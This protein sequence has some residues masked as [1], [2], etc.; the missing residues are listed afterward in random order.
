MLA[1]SDPT[2]SLSSATS[3]KNKVYAIRKGRNGISGVVV[4]SWAACKAHTDG[5]SGALYKSF[6]VESAGDALLWAQGKEIPASLD[7][8]AATAAPP[9]PAKKR[10]KPAGVG[11]SELAFST[12]DFD[13][14][15]EPLYVF[16]DGSSV[17]DPKI[18]AR[19]GGYGIWFGEK[20][21]RNVSEPFALLEP[22]NNRCEL[23]ALI[24][25]IEIVRE[26][27]VGGAID[28]RQ[29]LVICTDSRYAINCVTKWWDKWQ[30]NRWKNNT[31]KN[32]KLIEKLRSLFTSRPVALCYV[33]GHAG[34]EGNEGADRLARQAS[35]N[36]TPGAV[37][38][39]P[40]G[41]EGGEEDG[42]DEDF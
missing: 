14:G 31:V 40:A 16:A 11:D 38:G 17:L 32:R 2:V 25:T 8:A 10:R 28:P 7:A 35:E 9:A 3:G 36:A 37:G 22:T 18:N 41:G 23:M 12:K 30:S 4:G 34:I 26:Y 20:D 24:R 39:N 1:E 6:P 42:D 21:P 27:E 29:L 5:V 33:Q 13:R 19:R 15:A